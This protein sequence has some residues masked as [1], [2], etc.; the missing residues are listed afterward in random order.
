MP[1]AALRGGVKGAR[2]WAPARGGAAEGG[3][4]AGGEGAQGAGPPPTQQQL[5]DCRFYYG[6]GCANARCEF[7][8]CEAAWYNS[9]PCTFWLA[10]SCTRVGCSFR[11]PPR[12]G[13]LGSGGSGGAL[14]A[15][16]GNR[17]AKPMCR[18]F[19]QG[20]CAKG[21][22][23]PFSHGGSQAGEPSAQAAEQERAPR[24]APT[25]P[26]APVR[27]GKQAMLEAA[28]LRQQRLHE[29]IG[30]G[31]LG[32][33]ERA[34]AAAEAVR[35]RRSQEDSERREREQNGKRARTGAGVPV[36]AI[37]GNVQQQLPQQQRRDAKAGGKDGEHEP[38]PPAAAPAAKPKVKSFAE[39]MAEKKRGGGT[40]AASASAQAAKP[41]AKPARPERSQDA[42][43]ST[44]ASRAAKKP[45]GAAKPAPKSFA[46][47][48]AEKRAG[49]AKSFPPAA[50]KKPAP[51]P[52]P[53]PAES[54]DAP[55]AAAVAAEAEPAWLNQYEADGVGGDDDD[56]FEAE[57]AGLQSALNK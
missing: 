32:P 23:C 53:T 55:A 42:G 17:G 30:D 14:A 9:R 2:P 31:G 16:G 22:H 44:A 35:K 19:L 52:Q 56:D 36:H 10:G 29:E 33:Q 50:K 38:R 41:A 45:T 7:R 5:T 26:R 40:N 20:T 54:A 18:F 43:A 3:A 6:A 11:H 8:H 25:E 15:A 47:I 13:T 21:L 28:L 46:E 12:R 51:A 57:L 27:E 24:A 4:P 49:G 48:M 39:I 34:D 1:A 37:V